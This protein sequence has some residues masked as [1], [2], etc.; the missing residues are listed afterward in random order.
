MKAI[1]RERYGPPE[2][3]SLRDVAVPAVSE[4]PEV[5]SARA[6]YDADRKQQRP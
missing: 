4:R 2:S 6:Q 3:L 1:V 5:V